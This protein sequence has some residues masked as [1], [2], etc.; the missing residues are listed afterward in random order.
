MSVDF[1]KFIIK[2]M[3]IPIKNILNTFLADGLS[4]QWLMKLLGIDFITLKRSLMQPKDHY[5]LF[6]FTPDFNLDQWE[7]N[8]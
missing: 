5:F 7:L 2:L 8:F 1:I 4:L 3:E 6:Y